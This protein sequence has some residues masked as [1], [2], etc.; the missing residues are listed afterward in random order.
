MS[1]YWESK[2]IIPLRRR[3]RPPY[4]AY[5]PDYARSK[6]DFHYHA[7][8]G[9]AIALPPHALSGRLDPTQLPAAC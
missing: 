1:S 3:S 6:R 5:K 8:G 4:T 7:T 9:L 2:A